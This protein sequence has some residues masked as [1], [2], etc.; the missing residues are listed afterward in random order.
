MYLEILSRHPATPSRPIPLL[1]V[2][3]S[4]AGAAVWD[5]YF[6]PYCARHGYEAHAVSLR[7]HG[8]SA[9]HERLRWWSL[10]DYVADLRRAVAAL[11]RSPVLI[12]HSMGGMVVQKLMETHTV[13][14]VV[15][16]ASLPPQGLL[17]SLWGM[18]VSHP[19]LLQQL[20]L[21][22]CLGPQCATPDLM[23]ETLFSDDLPDERLW[24]YFRLLQGESIRVGLD[25]LGG[26]PLW[27][28]RDHGVPMLVIGAGRDTFFS[29]G[30][31]RD[32][33]RHYAAEFE[34]FP[35]L[36]H[37]LML[38]AGW[39]AVADRL[40]AWLDARFACPVTVQ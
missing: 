40:L 28:P 18:A 14:G 8:G 11:G 19:H 10:A 4:F 2:H 13:P 30:L 5:E 21:I 1:F 33:A 16:M 37:A 7:G 35:D 34:L 15:L 32:I 12:G 38:E 31:S 22:Q 39:Q 3:G 27:L 20:A 24:A 9:G 36:A 23:R 6:L 25:M 17:P 26:D 29:A